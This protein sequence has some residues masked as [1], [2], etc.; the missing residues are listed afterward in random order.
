MIT[1]GRVGLDPAVRRAIAASPLRDLDEA[2]TERLFAGA[3][4]LDAAAGMTL[5]RAGDGGS[6]L[7]LVIDGLIKAEVGSADGRSYTIRYARC[8]AIMGV[9]S[10]FRP[11]YTMPGSIH[12][13]VDSRLVVLDP[14][15]ARAAS[16]GDPEIAAAF[17]AELSE[18]LLAF[19]AEIPGSAF[20]TVRQRVA[21]HLLDLSSDGQDGP[22]LVARASQQQ[23]ADAVGTVR[24]VVVRELREL[25]ASGIVATGA[26]S[27][28]IVDPSRLLA[29]AALD[30]AP[31]PGT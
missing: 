21:R 6:H 2:A 18:R 27:I 25:R 4:I 10:L 3:T 16:R 11:E 26:R 1:R 24:E 12:A 22:A 8:G 30:G 20:T 23:L 9:A 17:L 5:R 7:E 19:V 29:V 28:T 13:L 31:A 15:T 14:P